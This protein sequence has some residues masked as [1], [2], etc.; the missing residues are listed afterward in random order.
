MSRNSKV[1]RQIRRKQDNKHAES[2]GKETVS[3]GNK[4]PSKTEKKHKKEK[5]W[6]A[7][8][9]GKV[10]APAPKPKTDEAVEE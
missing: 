10:N 7:I 9:A 6:Y 5:T 3:T 2:R 1:S 8:L 4:G